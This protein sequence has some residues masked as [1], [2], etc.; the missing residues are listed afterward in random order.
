MEDILNE[1]N[2]SLNLMNKDLFTKIWTSPRYR[3][4]CKT[5]D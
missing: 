4:V 5:I 1:N 2:E 3:L